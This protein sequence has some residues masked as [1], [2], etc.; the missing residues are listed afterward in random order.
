MNTEKR[1]SH[2]AS[3]P[4]V[5]VKKSGNNIT[6]EYQIVP[7]VDLQVPSVAWPCHP[8][9]ENV[10]WVDVNVPF[11]DVCLALKLH[12]HK[13]SKDLQPFINFL[14]QLSASISYGTTMQ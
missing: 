3:Q 10:P 1:A 9:S 13:K 7:S 6:L 8:L 14:A 11:V 4:T 12:S 2:I 5:N